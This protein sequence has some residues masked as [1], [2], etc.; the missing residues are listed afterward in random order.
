MVTSLLYPK[1]VE[2]KGEALVLVIFFFSFTSSLTIRVPVVSGK[3]TALGLPPASDPFGG[4]LYKAI[5]GGF[6]FYS[7]VLV[8]VLLSAGQDGEEE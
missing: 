2:P 4:R 7:A 1:R 3:C 6:F 5:S 8:S